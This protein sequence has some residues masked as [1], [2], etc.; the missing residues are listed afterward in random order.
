MVI[1][2]HLPSSVGVLTGVLDL[3]VEGARLILSRKFPLS[4]LPVSILEPE[5]DFSDPLLGLSIFSLGLGVDKIL[6]GLGVI[7][8][9]VGRSLDFDLS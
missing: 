2:G 7:G 8:G 9:F 6:V 3:E 5:L 1:E 4:P